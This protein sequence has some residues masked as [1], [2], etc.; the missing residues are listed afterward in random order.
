MLFPRGTPEAVWAMELLRELGWRC[1]T[2]GSG[3]I[4][5]A[6]LVK[7]TAFFPTSARISCDPSL[8][9]KQRICIYGLCEPSGCGLALNF[10][11]VVAVAG[12]GPWWVL[13]K[14]RL[15]LEE[16]QSGVGGIPVGCGFFFFPPSPVTFFPFYKNIVTMI[17]N[18][19]NKNRI[20]KWE[21]SIIL[22]T[23]ENQY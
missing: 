17:E 4:Y 1:R 9:V 13:S 3:F 7:Q 20:K 19:E 6:E 23:Q 11:S 10:P 14:C 22:P 8:F 12:L 18:V 2:S 15:I 21:L 16:W 5:S